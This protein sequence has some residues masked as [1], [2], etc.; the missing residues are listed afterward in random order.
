MRFEALEAWIRRAACLNLGKEVAR[1]SGQVLDTIDYCGFIGLNPASKRVLRRDRR[2]RAGHDAW[3]AGRAS[4]SKNL[5]IYGR[6]PNGG[7]L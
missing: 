5:I 1:W 4:C 3:R 6:Q 2:L 7:G